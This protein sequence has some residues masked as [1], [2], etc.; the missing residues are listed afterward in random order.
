MLMP[1]QPPK[2]PALPLALVSTGETVVVENVRGGRKMRQ[3]LLELGMNQGARIRVVRNEMSGPL[4]ISVK[5]DGRLAVGRGM[6]NHILVS[7]SSN[8]NKPEEG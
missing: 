8:G 4:I 6:S 3:R 1:H 2:N 7:M 5:E